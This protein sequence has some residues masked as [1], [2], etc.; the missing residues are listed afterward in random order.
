LKSTLK[1]CVAEHSS[2]NV[3]DKSLELVVHNMPLRLPATAVDIMADT[4]IVAVTGTSGA[5]KYE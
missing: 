2:A 5:L 3:S 4:L 1:A